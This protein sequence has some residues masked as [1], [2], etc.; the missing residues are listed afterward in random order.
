MKAI[1]PRM[2]ATRF[3]KYWRSLSERAER[4]HSLSS[5][6]QASVSASASMRR[7]PHSTWRTTLKGRGYRW[8]DGSDGRPRAW[9]IEIDDEEEEPRHLRTEIYGWEDAEP[10]TLR[11][12]AHDRYRA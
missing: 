12:T 8:S 5:C 1:G 11:F 7:T 3:W 10:L 6:A 4:R 2:I 9:W